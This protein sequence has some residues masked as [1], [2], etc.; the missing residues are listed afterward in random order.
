[1]FKGFEIED[2]FW[3]IQMGSEESQGTNKRE[4]GDAGSEKM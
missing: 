1:M 2:I 3:I 4:A